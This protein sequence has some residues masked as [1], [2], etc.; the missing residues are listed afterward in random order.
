MWYCNRDVAAARLIG[1]HESRISRA[2]VHAA[3]ASCVVRSAR[4]MA[5]SERRMISRVCSV[6]HESYRRIGSV[7]ATSRDTEFGLTIEGPFSV[8]AERSRR[9]NQLE[10]ATQILR[11]AND[12]AQR[13][14]SESVARQRRV[15]MN[16]C[17]Q[18]SGLCG[19]LVNH[20]LALAWTLRSPCEHANPR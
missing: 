4:A 10:R 8:R 2:A 14:D 17:R 9:T 15:S 16:F 3:S 18:L 13:R 6:R 1:T 19:L 20:R 11:D 7:G 12:A 5:S